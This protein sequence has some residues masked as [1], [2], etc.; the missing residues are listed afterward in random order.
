MVAGTRTSAALLALLLRAARG[1]SPEAACALALL[2]RYLVPDPD[3][4]DPLRLHIVA[5]ADW[6]DDAFIGSL[7]RGVLLTV[8]DRLPNETAAA[9]EDLWC[10][11]S[12][13]LA[14]TASPGQMKAVAAALRVPDRVRTVLWTTAPTRLTPAELLRFV[15]RRGVSCFSQLRLAVTSLDDR[16]TRLHFVPYGCDGILE[17]ASETDQCAPAG[18]WLLNA[19]VFLKPCSAWRPSSSHRFEAAVFATGGE[20]PSSHVLREALGALSRYGALPKPLAIVS[21]QDFLARWWEC[22]IDAM[23]S[24]GMLLSDQLGEAAAFPWGPERTMVVVPSGMGSQ[25]AHLLRLGEAFRPPLWCATAASALSVA[26]A[27]WLLRGARGAVLQTLAPLLAQPRPGVRDRRLQPLF[28]AWLLASLVVNAAFQGQL[29]SVLTVPGPRGEIDS[30]EQLEAS[31]LTLLVRPL[32]YMVHVRMRVRREPLSTTELR[33]VESVAAHRNAATLIDEDLLRAL[34]PVLAGRRL[35]SFPMPLQRTLRALFFTSRGSPLERPLRRLL[36]RLHAAGLMDH[37]KRRHR[38]LQS[39]RPPA[40]PAEVHE[41]S[42]NL[43]HVCPAFAVVAVG[44]GAAIGTFALESVWARHGRW[45]SSCT[46]ENHYNYV[47]RGKK[48]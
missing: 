18:G 12:H 5:Q 25:H 19:T 39:H 34:R 26:T 7:P 6:V 31:S 3:G 33:L 41:G 22:R 10:T 37:W 44:I 15:V 23:G 8:S 35:H 42:L 40:E 2:P 47:T 32:L 11:N 1:L 46:P 27:L 20:D 48:K 29:L 43:R 24:D 16:R 21:A 13:L 36:G 4:R 28:G 9:L 45:T 17:P 14:A 38:L 30:V